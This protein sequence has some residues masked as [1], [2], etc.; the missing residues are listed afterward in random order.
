MAEAN[1]M[2]NLSS[3]III[4]AVI[5]TDRRVFYFSSQEQG[6]RWIDLQKRRSH[7]YGTFFQVFSVNQAEEWI[8]ERTP[9]L[10]AEI[11]DSLDSTKLLYQARQ[12]RQELADIEY[13]LQQNLISTFYKDSFQGSRIFFLD[14]Y[15]EEISDLLDKLT[16]FL[17]AKKQKVVIPDFSY[18]H[19]SLLTAQISLNK[20][21]FDP[22]TFYLIPSDWH[23]IFADNP[24]SIQ[25]FQGFQSQIVLYKII[26]ISSLNKDSY[27]KSIAEQLN[28]PL[29][30]ST[31]DEFNILD[32]LIF[33]G[34]EKMF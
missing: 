4:D 27:Y 19:D 3:A 21:R 1:P 7:L 28:I 16:M 10:N 30:F 9:D 6:D 14:G 20:T 32:C 24:V 29:Y 34:L 2:E 25:L 23:R 22:N 12:R 8:K 5:E 11:I 15:E 26:V 33:M 18:Y 13:R 31:P 17:E